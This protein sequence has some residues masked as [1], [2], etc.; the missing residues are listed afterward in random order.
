MRSSIKKRQA[1]REVF[2]VEMPDD[3]IIRFKTIM[4]LELGMGLEHLK[5]ILDEGLKYGPDP[6]D[7]TRKLSSVE[8]VLRTFLP[9]DQWEAFYRSCWSK[10]HPVDFR[11]LVALIGEIFDIKTGAVEA[12]L[13]EGSASS[14]LE[15]PTGGL[16][17]PNASNGDSA[18]L[19][20][21]IS[22]IG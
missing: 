22:L 6:L 3:A 8:G 14:T 11:E 12:P 4:T 5:D 16:S 17:T 19:T 9:E 7:E 1:A 21:S 10:E 13:S 18:E 20:E 2:E 15:L